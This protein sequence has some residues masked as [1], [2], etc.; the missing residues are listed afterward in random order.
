MGFGTAGLLGRGARAAGAAARS[1]QGCCAQETT[2]PR[3]GAVLSLHVLKGHMAQG[4]ACRYRRKDSWPWHRELVTPEVASP[5]SVS[6]LPS[7]L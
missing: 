1:Q 2:L 5:S 6:L 3:T 4:G 7:S